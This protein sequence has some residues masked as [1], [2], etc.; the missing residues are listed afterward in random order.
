MNNIKTKFATIILGLIFW[1]PQASLANSLI[2]SSVKN[3]DPYDGNFSW[4]R[5]YEYPGTTIKDAIILRNIGKEAEIVKVYATDATANQAGSFT[6]KMDTDEQKG[7]GYWTKVDKKEVTLDPGQSQEVGFEINIPKDITPGQYFG[8][9][10]FEEADNTTC[11]TLQN[12]SGFCTG[13]IQI[14]TRTG[15]RIYLTIP[16]EAKHD[17]KL[18]DFNWKKSDQGSVHFTFNFSNQGNVAFEPKAVINIYNTWGTK[19]ATLES[20]LGKSLPGTSISPT[21]EW[22]YQDN[23]GQFTAKAEIYYLEDDQG[24]V[25]TLRGTVLSE[26]KDI[27]I[28]IF[29]WTMFLICLVAFLLLAGG[30]TAHHLLYKFIQANSV[31]YTVKKDENLIELARRFHT[32][33]QIIAHINK[34]RPPFVIKENEVINIPGTKKRA[35][36]K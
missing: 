31:K 26:K 17:I 6:P 13:N 12:V 30:T 16:G 20:K 32:R 2:V 35:N 14:K 22:K 25:D 4:F 3:P 29:P 28:Y 24:R 8:S 7:I 11:D 15:N 18:T 10:I 34:I 36:E 9:I 23:W 19:V 27:E 5:Y 21:L 33:W 1:L